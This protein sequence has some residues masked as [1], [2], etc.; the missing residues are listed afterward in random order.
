MITDYG[1][2]KSRVAL[3]PDE[4]ARLQREMETLQRDLQ[5]HEDTYGTNF[6]N[7]II[8]RG[9]LAKLLDNGRVVRF[10]SSSQPN[11][12]DAFQRIVDAANLDG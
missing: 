9:Y 4:L 12:L 3:S 8:V 10:L 5:A 6:L 7:L 1:R 11:M 2:S